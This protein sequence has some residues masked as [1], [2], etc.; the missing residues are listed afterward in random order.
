MAPFVPAGVEQDVMQ[1]D[2]MNDDVGIFKARAERGTGRDAH[3][4]LAGERVHHQ[5]A[6]RRIR[7]RQHLLAQAEAVEDVKDVGAELDA[8]ADGAELRRAFEHAR[9]PAA[10]RQSERRREP[11][12][13]AAD[14][15]DGVALR[16]RQN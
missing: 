9:R 6:S 15:E 16:H 2:A 7:D 3:Q 13:P 8:V 12:E 5:N 10:A 11:A 14:N 4:L 1:I